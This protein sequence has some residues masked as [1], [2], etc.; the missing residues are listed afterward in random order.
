MPSRR[1]AASID[2]GGV[3][4]AFVLLAQVGVL[5]KR[6]LERHLGV[7]GNHLRDGGAHVHRILEHAR[8]VVDGLL[9]LHLA[10]GD[11][12]RDAL[13]AVDVAAV[14]DDIQP[15][16]IVEV[17]VDIGHLRA[18]GRQEALEDQVVGKRV[19]GRDVER[20]ADDRASR[21]ATP[22][23]HANAVLLGPARELLHDEEVRREALRADN[24]VLV[25]EAVDDLLRQRISVAALETFHRHVAQQRLV[26]LSLLE[27]GVARQD[28]VAKLQGHIAF[29]R[30]LERRGQALRML[31]ERLGHLFRA[32]EVELVVRELHA[33]GV[34][35]ELAHA[36]AQHEVLRVGVLLAQVV[37]VVRADDLE[38]HLVCEL[39]QRVVE[40]RLADAVVGHDLRALVLQLDIEVILAEDVDEGL[41][42]LLGHLEL[43]TV[44]GLGDD[45]GDARARGQDAVMVLA[46]RLERD[47][48]FVIEAIRRG[49]RD[50]AHEVA[51]PTIVLRE[52]DHVVELRALVAAQRGIR[53]EIDL[54]ADDGL[55]AGLDGRLVE[56]RATVHV[57]VVRDGDGGHAELLGT[58]AQLADARG[59]VEQRI[60][61]VHVQVHEGAGLAT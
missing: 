41:R 21:R 56:L 3:R 49:I 50:D 2:L 1:F 13:R 45:A 18:L 60:L 10:V 52:Q 28:D 57:A 25:L 24:L 4:V 51:V 11:D 47:A 12:V 6:A 32:L 33:L 20:I 43:A 61:R 31:L 39:A 30:D 34:A 38:A 9:G 8:G 15:A 54:A 14:L 5:R 29:I 46:Q 26:C 19:E 55:D 58:R 16:L 37:Q 42:P 27:E 22:R 48:R 35:H 53:R 7:V 44:D 17:H 59:T 40:T 23:P 36:D